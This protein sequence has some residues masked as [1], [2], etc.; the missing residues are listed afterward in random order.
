[1]HLSLLKLLKVIDKGYYLEDPL[2]VEVISNSIAAQ[3]SKRL[4]FTNVGEL[5]KRKFSIWLM[6]LTVMA[7]CF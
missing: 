2:D 4:V 5:N 7:I 1:M 3:R 6:T